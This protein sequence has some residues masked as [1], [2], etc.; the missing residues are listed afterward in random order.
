[1]TE[2]DSKRFHTPARMLACALIVNTLIVTLRRPCTASYLSKDIMGKAGGIIGLISGVF[3][4]IAALFTLLAGGLGTAFNAGDAHNV[5]SLGWY[6]LA[7]AFL[8]IV[9]GSVAIFKPGAGAFGLLFLSLVG[10]ILGGTAVG[11]CLVLA[12]LGGVL[13]A[14]GAKHATTGK[15]QWWPWSGL[16]LGITIAI[17]L[18]LQMAQ[19]S[20]ETK[21]VVAETNEIAVLQPIP[22]T[23]A[24]TEAKEPNSQNIAAASTKVEDPIEPEIQSSHDSLFQEFKDVDRELNI[25]YKDAMNR[26]GADAKASLRNTQ[27][28][29]I[30]QR[31]LTCAPDESAG[32][33]PGSVGELDA[34]SCKTAATSK[35]TAEIKRL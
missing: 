5:V 14:I 15:R 6:G 2:L 10:A 16:P 27:R 13:A 35:R 21:D 4:V 31:D 11:I 8:V 20:Y 9:A 28:T 32:V 22:V 18:S 25:A 24:P 17:V 3:A 1:V 7:A 34:I 23:S 33:G 12:L 19:N 26:L 29:W 30:K